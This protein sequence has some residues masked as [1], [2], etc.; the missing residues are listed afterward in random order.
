MDA[1]TL[2][3]HQIVCMSIGLRLI[4]QKACKILNLCT[5][6]LPSV[7][8]KMCSRV[9]L[10]NG[11]EVQVTLDQMANKKSFSTVQHKNWFLKSFTTWISVFLSLSRLESCIVLLFDLFQ[12]QSKRQ[13]RFLLL[14]LLTACQPKTMDLTKLYK[15]SIQID[16]DN[17]SI[18]LILIQTNLTHLNTN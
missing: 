6:T 18:K 10:Y 7:T 13:P 2:L 14:Q 12:Y 5:K 9:L 1:A 17:L 15:R 4:L 3:D 16:T 8:L 11:F